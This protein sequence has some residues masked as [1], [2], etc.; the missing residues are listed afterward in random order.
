VKSQSP[1][2]KGISRRVSDLLLIGRKIVVDER[3]L[4][5]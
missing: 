3:R 4:R 1:H 2:R 5:R